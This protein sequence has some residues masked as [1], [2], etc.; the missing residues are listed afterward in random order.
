MMLLFLFLLLVVPYLLLA[1]LDRATDFRIRPNTRAESDS[2]S[3]LS[4]RVPFQL[5]VIWWTYYATKQHSSVKGVPRY[6]AN[7]RRN[8]GG[9]R[10]GSE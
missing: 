5:F 7:R 3:S 8:Y 2:H 6:R 1:P 4:F 10:T 9:L